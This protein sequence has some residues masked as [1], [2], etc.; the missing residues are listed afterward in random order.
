MSRAVP[1]PRAPQRQGK[2]G[3][4]ALVSRRQP[5]GVRFTRPMAVARA[6]AGPPRSVQHLRHATAERAPLPRHDNEIGA[7]A[8]ALG[9][10]ELQI[11]DRLVALPFVED[12]LK[13][14]GA[15]AEAA[16]SARHPQTQIGLRQHAA[17]G[18][19]VVSHGSGD[20]CAGGVGERSD[21]IACCDASRRCVARHRAAAASLRS[22]RAWVRSQ[23]DCCRSSAGV[24]RQKIWDG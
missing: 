18:R 3:R 21:A 14:G 19:E 23:I 22:S 9:A 4:G 16:S 10:A 24:M 2:C 7:S 12:R 13:V 5:G 11:L 6:N 8:A 1:T 17:G 20:L 15:P